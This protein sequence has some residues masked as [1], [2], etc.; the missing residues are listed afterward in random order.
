[1]VC[2]LLFSI[3]LG[4]AEAQSRKINLSPFFARGNSMFE[5]YSVYLDGEFSVGYWS[6]EGICYAT[7]FLEEFTVSDWDSLK[8]IVQYKPIPWLIRCAETL[9]DVGGVSSFDVLLELIAMESDE[10]KMSA[11]DSVN[12]RLSL[13]FALGESAG[14]IRS[15][16]NA[17]RNSAG[18]VASM[19]LNSLERKL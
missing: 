11:L 13:G 12:S 19:V 16:I 8:C 2:P 5:K 10:V 14:K 1:M 7:T 4:Q 17:A 15:A 6:D 3:I 18:P 9:G